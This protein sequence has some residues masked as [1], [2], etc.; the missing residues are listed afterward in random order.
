MPPG[1]IV[2]LIVKICPILISILRALFIFLWIYLKPEVGQ[3][4]ILVYQKQT[5]IQCKPQKCSNWQNLE[6]SL[7]T[8][9]SKKQNMATICMEI[10]KRNCPFDKPIRQR[11][12]FLKTEKSFKIGLKTGLPWGHGDLLLMYLKKVHCQQNFRCWNQPPDRP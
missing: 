2:I 4:A 7:S 1:K 12:C 8:E 6:I 10:E 3:K 5:P 9:H 11:F